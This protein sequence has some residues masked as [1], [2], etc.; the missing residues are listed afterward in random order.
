MIAI[1]LLA[2]VAV[3]VV[4]FAAASDLDQRCGVD[5][6]G[7]PIG[8]GTDGKTAVEVTNNLAP[9]LKLRVCHEAVH[10]KTGISCDNKGGIPSQY[11]DCPAQNVTK[12]PERIPSGESAMVSFDDKV[13]NIMVDLFD[14]IGQFNVS[15][16]C[17]I[18]KDASSGWPTPIVMDAKWWDKLQASCTVPSSPTV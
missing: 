6:H 17:Y 12:H 10:P 8:R 2:L 11:I 3:S 14:A 4:A 7:Q 16:S 1:K 15:A 18:L 13:Q 9:S 5:G